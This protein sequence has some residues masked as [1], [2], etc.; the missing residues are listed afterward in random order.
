MQELHYFL[1]WFRIVFSF[2]YG[3]PTRQLS[4]SIKIL[5]IKKIKE[6]ICKKSFFYKDTYMAIL[7]SLFCKE[8]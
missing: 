6:L 5:K 4:Y 7:E 3:F 8:S 1:D 2:D